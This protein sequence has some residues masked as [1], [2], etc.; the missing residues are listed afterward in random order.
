M[1]N[2]NYNL[3]EDDLFR[4]YKKFGPVNSVT[5]LKREGGVLKNGIAFIEMRSFE[6][7]ERAVKALNGTIIEGRTVKVMIARPRKDFYPAKESREEKEDK[8]L[9]VKPKRKREGDTPF[10]KFLKSVKK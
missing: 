9:R 3:G 4:I 6:H 2:L 1:S 5:F 10:A 8:K 7:A